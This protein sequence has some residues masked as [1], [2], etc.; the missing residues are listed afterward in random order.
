MNKTLASLK[1]QNK[2]LQ[3]QLQNLLARSDNYRIESLKKS[4]K[5]T[6]N[7]KGTKKVKVS[8]D[9]PQNIT[10]DIKFKIVTPAG[11]TVTN[12]DPAVTMN[13]LESEPLFYASTESKLIDYEVSKRIE[14]TYKPTEKL[15][16]GIY[17][18]DLYN[19]DTYIGS[20][21]IKLK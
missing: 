14:I 16:A 12:N 4:E 21:Q 10:T 1:E 18:I 11:K 6:V 9:I 17:K 2:N 7:A 5:L 20:C 13:I 15:A 8:F 3:D 19:K